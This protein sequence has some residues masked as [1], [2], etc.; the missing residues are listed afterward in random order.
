M[1][2]T[3]QFLEEINFKLTAVRKQLRWVIVL[4]YFGWGAFMAIALAVL[5][6]E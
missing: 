2:M 1:D 3:E 5:L 6:L 4:L